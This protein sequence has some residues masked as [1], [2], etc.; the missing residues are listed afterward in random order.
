MAPGSRRAVVVQDGGGWHQLCTQILT[1]CSIVGYIVILAVLCMLMIAATFNE[2]TNDG[3]L[4]AVIVIGWVVV[5]WCVVRCTLDAEKKRR[6]TE[7]GGSVESVR[8]TGSMPPRYS[9]SEEQNQET[10]PLLGSVAARAGVLSV[11]S[12]E[13]P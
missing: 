12:D 8:S 10:D 6:R 1:C 2:S 4:C 11:N 13:P 9:Q 5:G 7:A 3:T